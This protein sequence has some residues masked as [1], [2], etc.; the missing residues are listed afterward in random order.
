MEKNADIQSKSKR[1]NEALGKIC[2]VQL[3]VTKLK[4][5]HRILILIFSKKLVH[6][7]GPEHITLKK[8]YNK[9]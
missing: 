9:T 7:W 2:I 3:S 1:E 6:I 5:K 8:K 4:L